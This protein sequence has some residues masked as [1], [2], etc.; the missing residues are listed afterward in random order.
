MQLSIT[1]DVLYG[2]SNLRT[3]PAR[4][5][6][7]EVGDRTKLECFADGSPTP[8]FEW[9]QR[10]EDKEGSRESNAA[11]TP[12]IHSRGDGKIMD[13]DNV[14]YDNE[15][16]WVCAAKNNIK[17]KTTSFIDDFLIQSNKIHLFLQDL[18]VEF[19]AILFG[20]TSPGGRRC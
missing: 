10:V 9:L 13:F 4:F 3:K 6:N 11:V 1:F 15:G 14:T 20:W 8:E 5:I 18:N 16:M 19:S 2:P 7:L 12:T 17:G